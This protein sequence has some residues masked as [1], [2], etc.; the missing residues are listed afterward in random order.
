EPGHL[1]ELADVVSAWAER[2]SPVSLAV[3]GIGTLVDDGSRGKHELRAS[4]DQPE[5]YRLHDSLVMHSREYE[6][7]VQADHGLT[8]HSTLGYSLYHV[9]FLP[10]LDE[11]II[12]SADCVKVHVTDVDDPDP[13]VYDVR[14]GVGPLRE[15][16]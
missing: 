12:F 3:Q 10:K 7:R 5:L 14:L 16:G 13:Q 2:L 1:A 6:S 15:E 4:A 8:P 9:R 11:K